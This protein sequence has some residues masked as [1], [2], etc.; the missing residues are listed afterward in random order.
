MA[1]YRVTLG[2]RQG[3]F[4]AT[5]TYITR[6]VSQSALGGTIQQLLDRRNAM[7]FNNVLW[8]GVRIG[9][10][11]GDRRSQIYPPGFYTDEDDGIVLTVPATGIRST[12]AATDRTDQARSCLHI[13]VVFDDTRAV[14]RYLSMVP[15]SIVV[16]EPQSLVRSNDAVWL[17]AYNAFVE[18]L[19]G[20]AWSIQALSKTGDFGYKTI[21][22]WVQE[23]AAPFRVGA[24]V[25]TSVAPPVIQGDFIHVTGVRRRGTDRV[26][27]NGRYYVD[28]VVANVETGL[29]TYY[30]RG[31]ETGNV[32]SIKLPG[33]LRKEGK[34]FFAIQKFSAIRSGVHKRGNGLNP[35]RGR[36]V[37]RVKLDP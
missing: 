2:L 22:E 21:R 11:G 26:S 16:Q 14:I 5:E 27:Y 32:D 34:A 17:T 4:A 20:G 3:R 29:T 36:R 12:L 6:D 37:G 18:L 7:L 31:T 25:L 23:T 28:K 15:D 30:L 19:V 35:P 33:F 9:Q 10:T 8:D 24:S 1:R 13:R